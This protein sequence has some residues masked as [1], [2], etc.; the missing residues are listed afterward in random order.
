MVCLWCVVGAGGG[1]SISEHVSSDTT[2]AQRGFLILPSIQTIREN[3]NL[4]G[5][6]KTK[7]SFYDK[8]Y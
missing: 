5:Y 8:R 7:N 6:R 4:P 2:L 1:S 3:I